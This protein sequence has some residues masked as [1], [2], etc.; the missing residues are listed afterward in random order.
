MYT[1]ASGSVSLTTQ[2]DKS[3]VLAQAHG[4]WDMQNHEQPEDLIH[5]CVEC[6]HPA[7]GCVLGSGGGLWASGL[8][9]AAPRRTSMT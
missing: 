6:L 7:A 9:L 1:L 2:E 3:A 4:D 8:S 5:M